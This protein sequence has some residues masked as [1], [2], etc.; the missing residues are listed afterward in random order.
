[1]FPGEPHWDGTEFTWEC[2]VCSC[3]GEMGVNP[4]TG[5]PMLLID[6]EKGHVSDRCIDEARARHL[7]E[8]MLNTK[9][10][11]EPLHEGADEIER[12]KAME[13]PTVVI[14]R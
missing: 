8:I 3:G 7:Q 6:P 9:H 13:C 2:A 5:K 12:Y 11:Y 1:M 4:N 14:E 10:Y